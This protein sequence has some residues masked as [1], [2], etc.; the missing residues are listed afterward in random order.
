MNI[1]D[2]II[3]YKEIEVKTHKKLY[4]GTQLE[5]SEY[6]ERTPISLKNSLIKRERS[7]IISEFK[8]KSPSKGIIHKDLDHKT[9]D[10]DKI[11]RYVAKVVKGYEIA[12]AS[13]VSVLT[14]KEF[15]GGG[16]EDLISARRTLNIPVLR[17]DFIIDEYQI[18]DAKSMGADLILLIAACLEP[19]RLEK[20]AEF[21][22]SLKLEVL[23]EVHNNEE[24]QS[25]INDQVDI[26]GVNN[27]NLKTFAVSTQTS[28]ELADKI[29]DKFVKISESGLDK[30][31]D[32]HQLY[33]VGY[34]GFLI[35][36]SFMKQDDPGK[37]CQDLISTLKFD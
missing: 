11:A 17:K 31:E 1:L 7:G 23:M 15:F 32:I 13:A 22:H 14:D 16:K 21:A 29:P 10:E 2:K 19:K 26:I 4:P 27:R 28:L 18:V 25:H 30:A 3:R 35:G 20:L 8:L 36:E 5:K 37:A 24:L 6:F 12:G 34:R 9:G 33:K